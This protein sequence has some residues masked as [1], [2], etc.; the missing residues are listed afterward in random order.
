MASC[1]Q[2][3]SEED[4]KNLSEIAENQNTEK[5]T[6]NWVKLYK[7]WAHERSI[8]INL[9]KIDSQSLDKVLSQFYGEIC[10][11]DWREYE[12]DNLRV[13]QSLLYR[14][15]SE[16]A[17]NKS[18]LKDLVFNAKCKILEGKARLLR[19]QGIGEKKNSSKAIDS[20]E[21][22]ILW[23]YQKLGDSSSSSLV[24][25]MWF[26]CIQHFGLQGCQQHTNMRVESFVFLR[27][28]NGCEYIEFLKNP[29]KTRQGGLHSNQRARNPKMFA[30]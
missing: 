23:N 19:E 16:K 12:P 4:F 14:Y 22:Y 30:V 25:A 5:S 27:D 21:E 24:R 28:T 3:L 1:F 15:L 11:Q 17:Y 29:T 20:G 18:I 9:E 6:N 26:L 10:E 7:Q 8:N 2:L 13:M